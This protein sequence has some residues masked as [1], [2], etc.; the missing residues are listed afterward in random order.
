MTQPYDFGNVIVNT[1]TPH[2]VLILVRNNTS[3]AKPLTLMQNFTP[4]F[5]VISNTCSATGTIAAGGTC[6]FDVRFSPTMLGGA[7]T[8]IYFVIGSGPNDTVLQLLQG[9]GV[10]SLTLTALNGTSFG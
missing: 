2:D 3:T 5:T 1:T 7:V 6:T 10:E 4:D 8:D 9:I